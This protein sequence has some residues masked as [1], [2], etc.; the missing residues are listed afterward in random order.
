M[1][2]LPADHFDLRGRGRLAAGGA[3]DVV[4]F[5]ATR[6]TDRATYERPHQYAEGISTVLVNGVPVLQQQTHTAR[7]PGQVLRAR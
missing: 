4:I 5:D 7:R 1:T 2:S 3:A 6:V